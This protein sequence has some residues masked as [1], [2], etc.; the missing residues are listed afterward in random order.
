MKYRQVTFKVCLTL[1]AL[2]LLFC[3]PLKQVSATINLAPIQ[4]NIL[5]LLKRAKKLY[6]K[7]TY[8]ESATLWQE[9]ANIFAEQGNN[10][11]R[12]M[13]LSNLAL[14]YQQL[15]RWNL[16]EEVVIESLNLLDN[17]SNTPEKKR[18]YA[19][20]LDIKAKGQ[21]NTG[22]LE[23]ALVTWQQSAEI[24]RDI[25]AKKLLS[26][27]L[28]NQAQ[29]LQHLGLYNLACQT[30]LNSLK[31]PPTKCQ[32]SSQDL[33]NIFN[34][35][36][37]P[38][39]IKSLIGL[40]N[41]QRFLGALETC[42]KI[43]NRLLKGDQQL[44]SLEKSLVFLSLANTEI[45][46]ANRA[47]YLGDLLKY[48]QYNRKALEN[49]T[50]ASFAENLLHRAKAKVN[51]LNL[52]IQQQ[53][54][55]KANDILLEIM[56]LINNI[57]STQEG[58]YI[59]INLVKNLICLHQ[60]K[61]QCYSYQDNNQNL[62]K[63]NK[64]V[65][66]T[67]VNIL[68]KALD[69]S[70][71]IGNQRTQSYTLGNLGI[72]YAQKGEKIQAKKYF[73]QALQIAQSIPADD[74]AYQ[75]EWQLGKLLKDDSRQVAIIYY[76]NAFNILNQ[77]RANL[78]KLKPEIQFSFR[79][80]VEP[81]YREYI[82]LLMGENPGQKELQKSREVIE[83]LKIAELN[84]FFRDNCLGVQNLNNNLEILDKS[85]AIVYTI[86]LPE[87]LE[88]ILVL[89][90][91]P[92]KNYKA[93]LS[94]RQIENQLETIS[95][96]ISDP[97]HISYDI[98]TQ[99]YDYLIKPIEPELEANQIKNLVFV[100]DGLLRSIPLSTLYDGKQY[101][102]EKYSLAIVPSLQLIKTKFPPSNQL[103]VIAAG[104]SEARHGFY[105]LPEVE[106]ELENIQQTANIKALLFNESFQKNRFSAKIR[107]SPSSVIHL[108]THGQFSSDA[109]NTFILAWDG[110]INIYE[111][112]QI[113]RTQQEKNQ[114]IELLI[115]S[116][117]ETAKGDKRAALGLAGV[118]VRA[119]AQ[120]TIASLWQVSDESTQLLMTK[121]YEEL[122]RTQGDSNN[123]I[124]KAEALRR[125]QQAVKEYR[126][127]DFSH[128]FYW[129]AFVLVG[130]WL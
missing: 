18:I 5:P 110:P 42:E 8:Q 38:E 6:Q 1:L 80:S 26:K 78:V 76:Q 30:F 32:I 88:L 85:T 116:A 39:Q 66:E 82:D 115:L 13:A 56:P 33:D 57:N 106:Q 111:L 65:F 105:E 109:D 40:A 35:I 24:Y 4:G 81:V 114:P 127:A 55:E 27:N 128:P 117:C 71:N 10:L 96:Q 124:T 19:Q 20:T 67:S 59:K 84:N 122:N 68:K 93:Y 52:F 83:S 125:A 92:F 22:N 29:T 87:R 72:V 70:I 120:S 86:I 46:I 2:S 58:I 36:L 37:S 101:L 21:K 34:K 61:T 91:Q 123:P 47:N 45:A 97:N 79:E 50:K 100:A 53:K 17:Q 41:L 12:A 60:K 112:D 73:E 98:L 75:W 119:G 62:E 64:K 11:N 121:F 107:N 113:L 15:G 7:Q 31:L 48:K 90:G 104:L 49:L 89:P 69:E 126:G 23:D 130:N 118:A 129:S 3:W 44:S 63:I 51:I 74:I 94:E 103:D 9:L 95:E 54:W 102:M 43:L 14:S 99:W 77:L 16:A 108:A 25:Q 28:I